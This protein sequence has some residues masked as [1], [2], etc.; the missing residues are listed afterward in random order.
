MQLDVTKITGYSGLNFTIYHNGMLFY[1][2]LT[3]EYVNFNLPIGSYE[4]DC[5]DIFELD[6]PVIYVIPQLP[7]PEKK[8][9]MKRIKINRVVNKNKA[10]IDVRS[11]NTY[12]DS[13]I[14]DTWS[15]AKKV[16]ILGH[17]LGH[18]YYVTEL[19]CDMFSAKK[20]LENGFNPSQCF[21][22]S[23]MC[24]SGGFSDRKKDLLTFLKEVTQQ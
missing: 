1:S 14:D 9:V 22:A 17:E 10:S 7:E 2:V 16:F 4:I 18:N 11:G 12:L 21:H 3:D 24:L 19:F 5:E 6:N 23:F 13:K 20:M 8:V 15:T